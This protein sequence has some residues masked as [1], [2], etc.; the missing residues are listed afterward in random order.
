MGKESK[1]K[2]GARTIGRTHHLVNI[3]HS[4]PT[5]RDQPSFPT[6]TLRDTPSRPINTINRP[7]V[8]AANG[9]PQRPFPLFAVPDPHS[10][11]TPR[12]HPSAL[13]SHRFPELSCGRRR[14]ERFTPKEMDDEIVPGGREVVAARGEGER[15]HGRAVR[16]EGGD[17]SPFII[18]G[19]GRKEF[20]RVVVRDRGEQLVSPRRERT[21]VVVNLWIG[22][23]EGEKRHLFRRMPRDCFHILRVIHEDG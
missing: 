13:L 16:R 21:L 8:R 5:A 11:A 23:E 1:R 6:L 12:S 19:V 3:N 20:D 18:V 17:A 7:L 9:R 15:P 14:D 10:A 22:R 4:I 2:R